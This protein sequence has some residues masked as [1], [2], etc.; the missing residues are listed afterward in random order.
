MKKSD[1]RSYVSLEDALR[2]AFFLGMRLGIS[3]EGLGPRITSKFRGQTIT[4]IEK[5]LRTEMNGI[6]K[7]IEKWDRI[8]VSIRIPKL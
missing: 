3:L 1:L 7:E 2:E 8:P 6:F 4:Q 5:I